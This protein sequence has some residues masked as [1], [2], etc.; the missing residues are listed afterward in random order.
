MKLYDQ[1]ERI[2][3]ELRALGIAADAPLTGRRPRRPFG[4]PER[5][6]R[7]S[8]RIAAISWTTDR[9]AG[10]I[11]RISICSANPMQTRGAHVSSLRRFE[12]ASDGLVWT[13]GGAGFACLALHLL[14]G[15]T[16]S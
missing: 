7:M 16:R 15:A 10:S 5:P 8:K 12:K 4:G 13:M 11:S 14:A 6:V 1:M 9:A 3:N 2:H